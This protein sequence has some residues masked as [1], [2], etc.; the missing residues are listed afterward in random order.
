MEILSIF[1]ILK[2]SKVFRILEILSIF[3]IL[4][5]SKAFCIIGN[6]KYKRHFEIRPETKCPRNIFH[7]SKIHFNYEILLLFGGNIYISLRKLIFIS[8]LLNKELFDIYIFINFFGRKYFKQN[9][10]GRY[11]FKKK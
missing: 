2:Y 5:Y 6:I 9:I 3:D 10:V 7:F 8:Q 1:D 4:K 11:R